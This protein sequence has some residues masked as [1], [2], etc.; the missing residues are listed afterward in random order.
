MLAVIKTGGKQYKV[1]AGDIIKVEKIDAEKDKSINFEEVLM[2]SEED[3]S[4][5]KI[6]S[7]F[8]EG[9]MVSAKVLE[10]G[11]NKKIDVI[12]Y[13]RKIR[14]RRKIGHRQPFTQVK[15][16]KITT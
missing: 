3:G 5:V 13:K 8:I 10:Q 7:P 16:E 2:T 4:D 12:K 9:A 15:I 14:Y 1:K 6:G 11:R